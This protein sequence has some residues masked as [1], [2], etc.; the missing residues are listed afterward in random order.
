MR[1]ARLDL[2]GRIPTPEEVRSFLAD[3]S[4]DKREKWIAELVGGDE[5]VAKWSYFLMD[6][7]R[8]NGKMSGY[9]LFH[10]LLDQSLAADRP[11][12]DLARAIIAAS[13]KSSNVIAAV[14]PIVREHVEGKPGQVEHGDDLRKVHQLDTHDELT[15][16]FG[17]IFLGV[18]LSCISCHDGAGHL[19][20]VNV[21]LSEQTRADFFQQA[22]FLGNTRYIPHVEKTQ[23]IMGHFIVDDLAPGY[24]TK[25]DSM[26]RMARFGGRPPRSTCSPTSRPTRPP[27]SATSWRG[28]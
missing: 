23:A 8:A 13:G 1:R 16:Q 9:Q 15:I 20:K 27:I 5:W 11:Y 12:D 26:L 21:Y 18:N 7:F 24:D 28:C 6:A 19:E 2:S 25:G 14:N 22:A 10:H 17:K 3:P 4:P